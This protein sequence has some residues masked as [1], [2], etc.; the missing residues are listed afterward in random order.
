VVLFGSMADVRTPSNASIVRN[1]V[2]RLAGGVEQFRRDV[3]RVPSDIEGLASL[4][5]APPEAVGWRGPYVD[6]EADGWKDQWGRPFV[7]RVQNDGGYRLLSVGAD[8]RE[9]TQDDISN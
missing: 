7:Y 9:G 5:R 2:A 1:K 6:P 3:G 8:G 4:T